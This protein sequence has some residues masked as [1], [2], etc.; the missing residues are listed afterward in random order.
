MVITL[1]PNT[2]TVV[3]DSS[4]VGTRPWAYLTGVFASDFNCASGTSTFKVFQEEIQDWSVRLWEN[5]APIGNDLALHTGLGIVGRTVHY[6]GTWGLNLTY[7]DVNNPEFGVAFAAMVSGT[8]NLPQFTNYLVVKNFGF[9]IPTGSVVVGVDAAF[10]CT[11]LQFVSGS[12]ADYG[13]DYIT[14]SIDYTHDRYFQG[15]KSV[16][17]FQ[18]VTF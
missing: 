7:Q 11:S 17:A 4:L 15:V 18:K 1:G 13:V 8:G 10:K 16:Q 5:G 14:M 2:P 3:L 9:G 12:V 6:S